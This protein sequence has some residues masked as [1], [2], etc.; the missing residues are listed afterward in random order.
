MDRLQH[1]GAS[2]VRVHTEIVV[3]VPGI[4]ANPESEETQMT[5]MNVLKSVAL[6]AAAV[7]MTITLVVPSA[8]AQ[9]KNPVEV[10]VVNTP[11]QV[12]TPA[13]GTGEVF[14]KQ[15]EIT[16][17]P[18]RIFASNSFTVPSARRLVI[19][20]VGVRASG[21]IN[22]WVG[23]NFTTTAGGEEVTYFL[24]T[25]PAANFSNQRVAGQLVK[26]YAEP[27][28]TVSCEVVRSETT[29]QAFGQCSFSGYL[30]PVQ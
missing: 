30:V 16:V 22:D 10:K 29:A 12:Q 2:V 18:N 17:P 19:E 25:L 6:R 26:V 24:P 5:M 7:C 28:S 8:N 1:A 20:Y 13:S 11:L 4:A 14:Q 15:I 27:G 23:V 3:D 21:G 9:T